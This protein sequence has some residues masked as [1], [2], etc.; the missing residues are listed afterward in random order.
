[1]TNALISI[2]ELLMLHILMETFLI[3]HLFMHKVILKI[4][5]ILFVCALTMKHFAV[6]LLIN[7]TLYDHLSLNLFYGLN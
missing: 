4:L 2:S 1:M 6:D 7:I 5:T 3:Y